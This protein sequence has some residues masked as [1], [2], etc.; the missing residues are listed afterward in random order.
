MTNKSNALVNGVVI[1]SKTALFPARGFTAFFLNLVE[2][3]LF[4]SKLQRI[5]R[6]DIGDMKKLKVIDLKKNY[7][8]DLPGDLFNELK[9]LDY[10]DLSLNVIESLPENLFYYQRSLKYLY[11]SD[12]KLKSISSCLLENNL[13]LEMIH[14]ENNEIDSISPGLFERYS[15]LKEITLHG[16]VCTDGNSTKILAE[17]LE[18]AKICHMNCEGVIKNVRVY[19]D[20]MKLCKTKL[21]EEVNRNE[22]M[23]NKI[24]QK[25]GSKFLLSWN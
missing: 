13:K 6:A 5:E 4:S 1:D 10:I 8:S 12:N 25:S 18:F 7:L 11:L 24:G 22:K 23:K 2:F 20:K 16:N 21:K 14:L 19:E 15:D 3:A 9:H 17:V